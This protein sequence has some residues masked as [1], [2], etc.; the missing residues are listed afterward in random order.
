MIENKTKELTDKELDPKEQAV[1]ALANHIRKNPQ[2]ILTPFV[3][4]YTINEL[5]KSELGKDIL[6]LIAT[7]GGELP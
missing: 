2:L 7:N 4:E 6:Y 1:K 3:H 5:N